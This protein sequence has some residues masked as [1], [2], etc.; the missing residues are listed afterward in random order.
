MVVVGAS[1]TA[2]GGDICTS[3][4]TRRPLQ[5]EMQLAAAT[6]EVEQPRVNFCLLLAAVQVE[7]T[8]AVLP[9]PHISLDQEKLKR[10]TKSSSNA[11][12]L[13]LKC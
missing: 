11:N 13:L 1:F 12:Y 3:C 7:Q 2:G 5:A 10:V 9:P 6:M 8:S 4:C